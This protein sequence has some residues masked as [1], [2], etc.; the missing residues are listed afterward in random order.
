MI[1]QGTHPQPYLGLFDVS[2]ITAVLLFGT[3][4]KRNGAGP[5]FDYLKVKCDLYLNY[6]LTLIDL[7]HSQ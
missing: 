5:P 6:F 7:V 1:P 2:L 3:D 4:A